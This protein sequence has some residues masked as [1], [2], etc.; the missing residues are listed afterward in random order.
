MKKERSIR[1]SGGNVFADLRIPD[2]EQY[3]AK[4][5][6]AA[7]ILDIVERRGLTQAAAG[8]LL[9]ISQPKVSALLNGRLDGF[10]SDR[11]FRFLN[12]LGCDVRIVV[13]RP[14]PGSA[15]NIRVKAG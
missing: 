9:G 15:G 4:A 13:S 3:L 14:H 5:E 8:R 12:A 7:T 6:L 1:R 11:L 2:P 10:S